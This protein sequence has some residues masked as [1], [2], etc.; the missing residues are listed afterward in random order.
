VAGQKTSNR[1]SNFEQKVNSG[2]IIHTTW[3]QT[4]LQSHVIKTVRYWDK[5]RH[6]D[7]WNRIEDWSRYKYSLLIFDKGVQNMH[8]RKDSLFN[9]WY[10]E[11]WISTCRRLKL[12]SLYTNNN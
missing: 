11:N 5:N 10:W 4:I 8:W 12:D 9:K 2:G 3:L 1:Q 7:L 6:K